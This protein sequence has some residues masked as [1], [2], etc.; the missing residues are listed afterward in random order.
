[1]IGVLFLVL[2]VT[3]QVVQQ[4]A[5]GDICVPTQVIWA[6]G[7]ALTTLASAN[8]VQWRAGQI[9][10]KRIADELKETR[11]QLFN[12]LTDRKEKSA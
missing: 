10:E 12:V 9:K 2:D 3:Y 11:D 1:M 5:S 8:A 4:A 7:L 6:V